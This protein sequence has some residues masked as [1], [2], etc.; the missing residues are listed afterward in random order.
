MTVLI[1]MMLGAALAFLFERAMRWMDDR[2]ATKSVEDFYQGVW[3]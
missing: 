1:W 2:K 3:R